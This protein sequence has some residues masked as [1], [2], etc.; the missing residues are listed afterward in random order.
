[1]SEPFGLNTL[2]GM[3]NCLCRE[4]DGIESEEWLMKHAKEADIIA[5]SL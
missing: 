3:T 2:L 4:E 5:F 1:M